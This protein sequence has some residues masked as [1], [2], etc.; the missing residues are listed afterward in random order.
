MSKRQA[1]PTAN[2]NTHETEHD[3]PEVLAGDSP[4]RPAWPLFV[5]ASVWVIWI[6]FLLAMMIIRMRTTAV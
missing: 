4:P 2:Q 5:G 3:D 6:G 1:Q